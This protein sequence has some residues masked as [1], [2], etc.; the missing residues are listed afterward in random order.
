KRRAKQEELFF[1]DAAGLSSKHQR[2][3]ELPIINELRIRVDRWRELRD[4]RDWRVSPTTTRL[5]QH[6]RNQE[7]ASLRPFFCQIEAVEVA[8]WL[9]EVAPELGREGRIFLEHLANANEG[10]NP[11]LSRVA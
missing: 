6:W 10:A 4:P 7:F 8:I 11:G 2:Y 3:D 1:E 5:L 9:T